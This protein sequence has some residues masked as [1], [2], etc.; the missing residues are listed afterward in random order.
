M[1][2][3]FFLAPGRLEW[4]DVPEPELEAETDALMRPIAVAT[5][6]LDTA[7][8]QGTAPF[9]GPFPL[10]HEGV[11]EVVVVGDAVTDVAVG[12]RVIVPF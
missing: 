3:L 4:R 11:A 5:C 2:Q 9:E 7:L 12:Q 10:S 8:L 1:R 6:D